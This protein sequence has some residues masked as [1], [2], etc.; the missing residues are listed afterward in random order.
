MIIVKLK[1]PLQVPL[2]VKVKVKVRTWSGHGQ[3]RSDSNSN[4]NSKVG[5]EL[6]IKIGFHPPPSTPSLNESLERRVVY[7][8]M[9]YHKMIKDDPG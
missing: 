7:I 9:M 5:L 2:K 4:S 3:V 8:I 6:Y 1:V